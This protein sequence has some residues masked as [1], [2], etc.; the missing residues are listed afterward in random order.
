MTSFLTAFVRSAVVA[1]AAS[2]VFVLRNLRFLH[3]WYPPRLKQTVDTWTNQMLLVP[4][5]SLGRRVYVDQ[6]CGYREQ[7]RF[8]PRCEASPEYRLTENE[9]R[10]FYE[11]GFLGPFRAVSE[12]EMAELRKEFVRLLGRDSTTY[13]FRTTRDLHLDSPRILELVC[14]PAAVQRAAQLLSPDLLVWRTNVFEKEAGSPEITWHQGS[15]FLMEQVYKPALEPRDPN[16]IFEIGVWMAIDRADASNG[17]L[18]VVPGTHHTIGTIRINGKRHFLGQKFEGD[19]KIDPQTVVSLPCEPG[20]FLLFSERLIHG[21]EPNRS[22]R[23]RMS[24][25]FRFV[26]PD[27]AVC[28]GERRHRVASMRKTFPLDRW[29][30]VLVHGR[31][32]AGVNK[33][34]RA[35]ELL[36]RQPVVVAR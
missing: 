36:A 7:S 19:Y 18:Q 4:I 33:V 16:T 23:P 1:T 2:V 34:V 9:V 8:E 21:S 24:F 13:G 3:R 5:T 26:E 29:A 15:T 27:T 30:C 6:P 17:C 12:A 35:E 14:H 31:D 32:T 25:V 28:R 11:K 20:E 22:E 10:S